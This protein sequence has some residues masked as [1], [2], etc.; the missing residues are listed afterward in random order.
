MCRLRPPKKLKK[1]RRVLLMPYPNERAAGDSLWRLEDNESVRYFKGLIRTR[2]HNAL[3][4]GPPIVEPLRGRQPVKWIVAIDGSSVTKAVQNG[5]P[6]AEAALFNAAVIVIDVAELRRFDTDNVPSPS[7]LRDLE[8]VQTMSAV[9]PGQNVVG[10]KHEEE[11]PKKFFRATVRKELDFKLDP[12]HDSLLQTFLSLTL[13]EGTTTAQLQCPL[14]DCDERITRPRQ[15]QKC[16]CEQREMLYPTDS[17]RMHER[18]YDNNSSEQAFT[19]FR[20]VVEH[21]LLIN[22]ITYFYTNQPLHWFDDIAFVMDGPL[23]IFGMPAWLKDHIQSTLQQIH[24]DLVGKGHEGL[25]LMGMEKTGEFLDHLEELDWSESEGTRQRLANGTAMAPTTSYIYRYIRPNPDASNSVYGQQVYYGRK[26]L[27]KT[28]NGQHAVVMTPIVN[29]AGRQRD[30]ID[31]SAFPRLGEAL[32]I[33]DELYTHLYQDGFLPL[34]RAN[35][36]AAI[37]LRKGQAILS[38][39]FGDRLGN[40]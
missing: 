4:E 3:R 37:P 23:A 13:A 7:Q 33:V 10:Q 12:N 19:A 31:V 38:K 17:L 9:L 8:Q 16:P 5:F 32:D 25:L 39:L 34:V 36:H 11:T 1:V 2:E 26:I 22:I 27:Y 18:F 24:N 20:M 35:A 30:G 28:R 40:S 15:D 14:E 6:K 21:L 29:A